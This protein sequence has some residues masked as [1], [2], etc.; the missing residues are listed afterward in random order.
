MPKQKLS[1]QD[2]LDE[3]YRLAIEEGLDQVQVKII[4]KNLNCSVQPVYSYFRN[5]DDLKHEVIRRAFKTFMNL[6]MENVRLDEDFVLQ[7]GHALLTRA[8]ENPRLY[9]Y[10]QQGLTDS[11][12]TFWN[13]FDEKTIQLVADQKQVDPFKARNFLN[14]FLIYTIG[15][16]NLVMTDNM[17]EEE[18]L[19]QLAMAVD[20]FDVQARSR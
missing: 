16:V 3:G 19:S 8:Y 5:I 9:G 14:H 15:L 18:A 12:D 7:M 4:A 20:A 6:V 11:L 2:I 10:F 1:R 17:D 13:L